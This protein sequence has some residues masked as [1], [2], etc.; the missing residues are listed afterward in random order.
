MKGDP[1]LRPHSP[2]LVLHRVRRALGV[3]TAVPESRGICRASVEEEVGITH[4]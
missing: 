4:G 2:S 1:E 3:N